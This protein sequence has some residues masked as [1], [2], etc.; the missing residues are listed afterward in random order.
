M[1]LMRCYVA[2]C[3]GLALVVAVSGCRS[4]DRVESELRARENDVL[5]LRGELDRCGVYNQALQ[6]ENHS[7]RGQLGI[8]PDGPPVAAYPVQSV[9]L[10]RQTGG[11]NNN[12]IYQGDDALQ[13]QIQPMDPEGQAIKAPGQLLINVQ[14]ITT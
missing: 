5:T 9:V 7:L 2:C 1:S 11:R 14:E 6:Q 13:V 12:D 3:F 8:P 10:G 4:C